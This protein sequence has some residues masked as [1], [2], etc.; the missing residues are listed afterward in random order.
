[1]LFLSHVSCA[2]LVTAPAETLTIK[3]GNPLPIPKNKASINPNNG[4]AFTAA[5]E[6]KSNNGAADVPKLKINP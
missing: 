3:K 5:T 2:N 4:F 1:M 6:S